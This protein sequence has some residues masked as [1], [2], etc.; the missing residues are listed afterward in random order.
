MTRSLPVTNFDSSEARRER[1]GRIDAPVHY[2]GIGGA[3]RPD[4]KTTIV[5]GG[6]VGIVRAGLMGT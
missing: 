2:A 6:G 4:G 1:F 3:S 5:A